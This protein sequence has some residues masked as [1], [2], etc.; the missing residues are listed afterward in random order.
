MEQL[1]R[2]MPGFVSLDDY[3][4]A[5]GKRVAIIEFESEQTLRAWREHP[6]H[7]EAQKLGRESFYAE[8]TLEVCEKRRD[9][10]FRH[11]GDPSDR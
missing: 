10:T 11:E 7:Q 9:S 2:S 5:S 8:Y 1:A 3:T 6:E 4:D